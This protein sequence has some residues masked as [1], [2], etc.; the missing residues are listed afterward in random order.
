M[1]NRN[2]VQSG[3]LLV[4]VLV[5]SGVFLVILT[6]FLGYLISQHKSAEH[7][8]QLER[9]S[10]IAEAGLNYYRW[11]LA[12]Y[13]NDST[14]GTG[15]PGPYTHVYSDPE[16]GP[17]GEFSLTVASSSYCGD[18]TSL[19]VTSTGHTYE[20]PALN[21]TISARYTQ[22]TVAE[23][24]YIINSSVWAGATQN[25][26]GPYHS[27]QGIRMD[28]T[29]Q[30]TVTSGLLSWTC[31]S[32]FGCSPSGTR[33]GVFTT[34]ANANQLLFSFPSPPI[35][36]TDISI[37][38]NNILDRAQNQGG[39]YIPSSGTHGYRITFNG[40]GTFTARTV[41]AVRSYSAYS[42]E[43]GNHTERNIIQTDTNYG[44]YAINPSC[45]I[46]YVAD[47]VWLQGV[48]DEKVTLA[49][50]GTDSTG[51]NPSIILQG[52]ITYSDPEEDGLLAIA[53][54]NVLLGVDVPND[55]F[56]NGIYVA[57]TG[58]FGRNDYEYSNLPN[59][60]GPLDFRPY[61]ERNS[62]TANGTIVSN[63]RVGTQ[64][65]SG[66]TFQSGFHNRYSSYDR[67]LVD[68]PPPLVP[69]TSDVYQFV[70]WRESE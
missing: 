15:L 8:Y 49:A 17:I 70:E 19:E 16:Q 52:N 32:S 23:Y 27:N 44:T 29:N 42:T 30:S 58:R 61:Y 67:N 22:P 18:V 3:Y 47:K 65:V 51:A 26:I 41:T 37:D 14:N 46:I 68:N 69:N 48:L 35:N 2:S 39:T 7:R 21:R 64:W 63:G 62:L 31:T 60:S 20:N 36:F 1:I 66:S 40:N 55:M 13:P 6:S 34:T 45:P 11:Y 53:E 50:A 28:G 5:F 10:E 43:Q 56:I 25:F 59:P 9:A 4:L 12:H 38:L 57:Q 24:A 54:N 33:D